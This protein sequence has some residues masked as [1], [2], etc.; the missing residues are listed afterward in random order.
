MLFLSVSF[1]PQVNAAIPDGRTALKQ[2]G[3]QIAFWIITVVFAAIAGLLTGLVLNLPIFENQT[4]ST[5]T[6][7]DDR[8][9]FD[10]IADVRRLCT[11]PFDLF[12]LTSIVICAVRGPRCGCVRP[13]TPGP[14]RPRCSCPG[15]QG[16]GREGA[17]VCRLSNPTRS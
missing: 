10:P 3:F 11:F 16:I 13:C 15:S 6:N 7:N 17:G 12:C 9:T 8:D 14:G 5:E 1:T 4:S 2:G